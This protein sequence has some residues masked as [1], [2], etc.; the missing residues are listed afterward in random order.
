MNRREFIF[1]TLAAGAACTFSLTAK[2]Q[3][4]QNQTQREAFALWNQH[5]MQS[6]EQ[7]L[8][9]KQVL[10]ILAM[11]NHAKMDLVAGNTVWSNEE[12]FT[13]TEIAWLATHGSLT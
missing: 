10:D 4:P 1:G 6:P 7:F 12:L 8:H 5:Y 11:R 9:K 13:Q 2:A 3:E